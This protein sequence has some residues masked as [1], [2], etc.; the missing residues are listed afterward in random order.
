MTSQIF[1]DNQ[2]LNQIE[3]AI[4]DVIFFILYQVARRLQFQCH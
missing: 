2:L 4:D 3:R 1:N